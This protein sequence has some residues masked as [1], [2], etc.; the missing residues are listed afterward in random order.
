M[1]GWVNRVSRR[2]ASASSPF[3]KITVR[4]SHPSSP[5]NTS[6][7]SSTTPRN[8]RFSLVKPSAHAGVL[9]AWPGKG[10]QPAYRCAPRHAPVSPFRARP[11]LLPRGCEQPPRGGAEN[12]P[13][14]LQRPRNVSHQAVGMRFE[15][16]RQDPMRGVQAQLQFLRKARAVETARTSSAGSGSGASSS[17]TCALVRRL[18]AKLTPPA[19]AHCPTDHE[20]TRAIS[21]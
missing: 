12:L 19:S 8:T 13:S 6:A 21:Y 17:T 7:H 16:A 3:E 15:M 2:R 5:R 9:R 18:R 14:R 10:I 1:A 20:A 11:R 4:K